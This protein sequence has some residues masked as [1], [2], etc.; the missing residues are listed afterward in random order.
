MVSRGQ[1]ARER[2]RL[3]SLGSVRGGPA[4]WGLPGLGGHVQ[5][6]GPQGRVQGGRPRGQGGKEWGPTPKPPSHSASS[7]CVQVRPSQP[8]RQMQEK[9]S[10]LPTQVP[11]FTQGLGRQ[12]LFLAVVGG[13]DFSLSS[14]ETG[15]PHASAPDRVARARGLLTDV[16]GAAPPAGGAGAAEGV[17]AVIAGA[18]IAAG[19]SVTLGLTCRYMVLSGH[20]PQQ[21]AASWHA[22]PRAGARQALTRVAGLALPA[23]VTRAVEVVDQVVAAAAAVAGIGEAVVGIWGRGRRS[24]RGRRRSGRGS[25]GRGTRAGP[26]RDGGGRGGKAR[27]PGVGWG[28]LP[29]TQAKQSPPPPGTGGQRGAPVLGAQGPREGSATHS[30]VSQSSP[31]Q[32]L[33]QK[34]RKAS[35]SS[36]QV[37]PLRHG[38]PRQSS[39][40][41]GGG[42]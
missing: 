24:A 39:M 17:A 3:G 18:P 8:S 28:G 13:K 10:P 2:P 4:S 12:L 35:T 5:R 41:A 36:M 38:W 32:P 37:P 40:S 14:G 19:V 11:P 29:H 1:N 21:R 15:S 23:V 30:L 31:S 16:A 27:C 9:E 7:L 42:G 34:Q 25:R 33:G 6:A 26:G 22:A 20:A